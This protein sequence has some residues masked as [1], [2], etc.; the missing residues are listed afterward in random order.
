M[1]RRETYLLCYLEKNN[2]VLSQVCS[3]CI[4]YF[5]RGTMFYQEI[6]KKKESSCSWSTVHVTHKRH[7]KAYS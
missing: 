2:H 6:K 5:E 3:L 4:S 1:A 7:L